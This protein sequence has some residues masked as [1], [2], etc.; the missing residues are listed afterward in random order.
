MSSA[1]AEVRQVTAVATVTT[2]TTVA[3]NRTIV[4]TDNAPVALELVS[5]GSIKNE[6]TIRG[7]NASAIV[8]TGVASAGTRIENDGTIEASRN[9]GNTARDIAAIYVASRAE[10]INNAKGVI[11]GTGGADGIIVATNVAGI[12]TAGTTI[13]NAGTISSDSGNAISVYGAMRSIT[14]SGT[15]I[16]ETG[17]AI[18]LG[19][20]G[21]ITDGITNSGTIQGGASDGSGKAIDA[22]LSKANLT[23]NNSGKIVGQILFGS[24]TDVLNITG[25]SITGNV[26]GDGKDTVNFDL[27]T[28]SFTTGGTF[29]GIGTL[30]AKTGTTTLAQ[31]VTGAT[32]FNIS[33]GATVKQQAAIAAA[34]V[35]NAGT[36]NVGASK[37]TITGNYVQTGTLALTITDAASGSLSVSGTANVAGKVAPDTK[38]SRTLSIAPGASFTVLESTGALTVASST[39]VDGTNTLEKFAL[40][41]S[42][43]L[44]KLV[45]E[46]GLAPDSTVKKTLDGITNGTIVTVGSP[47]VAATSAALST[48]LTTI[49]NSSTGLQGSITRVGATTPM[50]SI[51]SVLQN[52]T[53]VIGGQTVTLTPAQVSDIVSQYV[54]ELTP[55]FSISSTSAGVSNAI[56][57]SSSTTV[58][59]RVASLRSQDSQTGMAAGDMVGRGIEMWALPYLSTFTQDLKDGVSGYKADTRGLT[60][61]ADTVVADNLRVGLAL[62]YATT[63]IDGKNQS[64][65][66]KSEVDSYQATLYASYNPAPFYVDAQLGYGFSNNDQT[67]RFSV[68][69]P[70]S[71][72]SSI[73]NLTA[74]Y[75]SS[76]YRARITG[77]MTK[78][79]SGVELTPSLFLQYAYSET[80]SYKETGSNGAAMNSSDTTSVQG[81][82]GL[83]IAYPVAIDGGR[84]IPELRVGFTREFNDD[85]PSTGFSLVNLPELSSTITGAKP[86]QNIYNV[87]L[88]LTFLSN[89]KLSISGNYDYQGTDSSDGHVGYVR[90][91]Y[92]F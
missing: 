61:G 45:R 50:G 27:G 65:G 67:R 35:T 16:S 53:V 12:D 78:T 87:G 1:Y 60:V 19:A 80:D 74:D 85:A 55:D 76:S 48:A 52:P 59:N 86:S 66:D 7:V 11:K 71:G 4:G 22:S 70:S 30:N 47:S 2:A 24:G 33:S 40:S 83:R 5:G 72:F 43:N 88:G 37:Q 49:V 38:A 81:G 73:E 26:S 69:Q 75:D 29:S 51:L 63:D 68:T 90:L 92:K 84:L 41:Q 15:I 8:V 57:A 13:T 89:D 91:R 31:A 28:G 18:Y 46:S 25:G 54:T 17:T 3:A 23:I 20:D 39:S 36:L 58:S 42:G 9:V 14:N 10:I 34:T 79:F 32:A 64:V 82:I 44:L 6:G 77:G 62:G 56:G 21:A